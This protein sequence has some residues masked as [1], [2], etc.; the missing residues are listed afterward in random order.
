MGKKRTVT[1][2][3]G[4]APAI[5]LRVACGT[6]SGR[7]ARFNTPDSIFDIETDRFVGRIFYCFR[8][9]ADVPSAF[10]EAR[11]GVRMSA[12]VQGRFKKTGM[13]MSDCYTGYEFEKKFAYLPSRFVLG[14]VL[15]AAQRL[16]EVSAFRRESK[17][18]QQ[19]EKALQA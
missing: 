14:A 12:T 8:G 6:T 19:D 9:L 1:V 18:M 11:K 16:S 7:A 15:K 4:G 10:L 13:L 2:E 17:L 3:A 5:E